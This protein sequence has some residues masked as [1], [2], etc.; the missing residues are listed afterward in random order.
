MRLRFGHVPNPFSSPIVVALERGYFGDAG[1][2][3]DVT[4]FGNGSA[5]AAAL[6]RGAVELGVGGHLQTLAETS[7]G[8]DQVFIG[9]LGF[10]RSPD[11]L[12]IT[13]IAADDGSSGF[14]LEGAAVGVSARAAISDLQLRIYMRS[15]GADFDSLRLVPMPFDELAGALRRGEIA[16]ASAPDPFAARL[17]QQG[18]GQIID[19]GSLSRALPNG[20]RVLVAGLVTTRA[21]AEREP[22]AVHRVVAAVG[23]AIDDLQGAIPLPEQHL[24]YFDRRFE[25]ADL[26]LVFDLAIDH[27]LIDRAANAAELILAPTDRRRT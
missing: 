2:D 8:A 12:P 23:R 11:H 18:L 3:L 7:T 17:V 6:T 20:G 19:R 10:E 21:F 5:F 26:Q 24:P 13:L 4:T 15:E 27:R 16:A 9:P 1:I 14:A 22:D 25:P